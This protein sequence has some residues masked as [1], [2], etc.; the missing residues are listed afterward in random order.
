MDDEK[1]LAEIS[2]DI[3]FLAPVPES[4]IKSGFEALQQRRCVCFGSDATHFF[5]GLEKMLQAKS[6]ATFLY[7]SR[8]NSP[9]SVTWVGRYIGHLTPKNRTLPVCIPEAARQDS[10]FA[11]WWKLDFLTPLPEDDWFPIHKLFSDSSDKHFSDSFAP[12][13]PV[14]VHAE[15]RLLGV[16]KAWM[17]EQGIIE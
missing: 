5:T 14:R 12:R 9:L 13:A 16:V 4:Y 6:C 11:S 3:A 17:R 15:E 8:A 1:V 2:D 10:P 7:A